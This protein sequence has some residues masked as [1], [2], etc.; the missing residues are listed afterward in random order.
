MNMHDPRTLCVIQQ[1]G[2]DVIIVTDGMAHQ[3]CTVTLWFRCVLVVILS[4][5]YQVVVK[6]LPSGSG[7]TLW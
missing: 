2:Q 7:V 4:H 3:A 5:L 6:K 1:E